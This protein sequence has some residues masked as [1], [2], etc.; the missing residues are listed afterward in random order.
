MPEERIYKVGV[1]GAG[2]IARVHVSNLLKTGRTEITWVAA[3]NQE[4]LI[5]F[6][7]EYGIPNYTRDYR[8]ILRDPP[9]AKED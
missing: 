7:A 1:I 9:H 6:C 3:R 8:E 2:M 4:N 5:G